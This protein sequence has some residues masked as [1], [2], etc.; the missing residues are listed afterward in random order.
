MDQRRLIQPIVDFSNAPSECG[1][2]PTASLKRSPT[3]PRPLSGPLRRPSL[4][5]G[6]KA[7]VPAYPSRR[8]IRMPK[9][10]AGRG[11]GNWKDV[12]MGRS[13]KLRGRDRFASD[14]WAPVQLLAASH[15]FRS[16]RGKS[17]WPRCV[18]KSGEIC[19]TFQR[20]FSETSFPGSNPG[21]P[22]DQ[23]R[24]FWPSPVSW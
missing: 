10:H 22:A 16:G 20:A 2:C 1:L 3:G 24:R 5:V 4:L 6:P 23:C 19:P 14:W 11:P 13:H 8:L 17:L 21:A 12:S 18:P 9:Q 15:N 7:D